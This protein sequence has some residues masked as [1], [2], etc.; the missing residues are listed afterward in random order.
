MNKL[1]QG[2]VAAAMVVTMLTGC[3]STGNQTTNKAVDST[4]SSGTAAP[5][6]AKLSG[7]LEIQYFVGGYGDKWWK[8][9]IS[10]FKEANPGLEIVEQAGPS[11]NTEMKTRWIS[12]NPP[13]LVYIAGAGSSEAQMV[14]D[15]QLM[16]LTEWSKTLKLE[17]GSPLLSNLFVQPSVYEG[18]NYSL[19]LV[20]DA[21]GTWYDRKWLKDNNYKVPTDFTSWMDNMKE[22]K[23]KSGIAPLV[24]DGMHPYPLRG[25]F[26]PG[27][28]SEGGA[29]FIADLVDAKPGAWQSEAALKVAK[30]IE[31]MQKAGLI[32]PGFAALN[33]TQ[34]QMNFLLHKNAFIPVGFWLPF[35]M[36]K[37][38]PQGFDFGFSPTPLQDAG[39]PLSIVPQPAPVA[40]AKQAKN[41]EAAKSFLDF[42]FKRK[43]AELSLELQGAM[44][45][46][47]G[48]DV[49][50]NEKIPGYLKEVN[51]LV[52]DKSKVTFSTLP[53]PMHADLEKPIFNELVSLMV[54]KISAEEF[55][56]RADKAA[57][58]FKKNQ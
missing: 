12:N 14:A 53:H 4:P 3:G 20:F 36:Q 27:A 41:P 30:K 28:A 46:V 19:P 56:K 24:T 18:K 22:I 42:V 50:K 5:A 21:W 40:I 44:M 29:A 32:D 39:K 43:Y 49:S 2:M 57:A 9:A 31:Q 34:S 58:D 13:D 15:G 54:G 8:K 16:D 33:H 26:M 1:G 47:K 48:V 55:V 51:V 38:V 11:V 23:A 52:N 25:L 35:E 37:D 45:S 7:K 10:D 17:D 6:K